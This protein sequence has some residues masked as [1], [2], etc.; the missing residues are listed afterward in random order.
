MSR[1][2]IKKDKC[3]GCYLCLVHCPKGLIKI[4]SKLNKLGVKPARF[5]NSKDKKCSGCNFC[6][7]IC[8]EVCIESFKD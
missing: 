8:P 5:K 7:M 6:C 2:K 3:K 1:I 4:D